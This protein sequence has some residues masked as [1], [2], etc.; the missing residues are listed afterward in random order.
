MNRKKVTTVDD[1]LIHLTDHLSSRMADEQE[2]T[3]STLRESEEFDRGVCYGAINAI[4]DIRQY[5][6]N[7]EKH[8][9]D[10]LLVDDWIKPESLPTCDEDKHDWEFVDHGSAGYYKCLKCQ[11][12]YNEQT[13]KS[14]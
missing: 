9:Y 7:I 2:Y 1:M 4:D 8:G 12:S 11:R 10:H 5:L 13:R 6:R 14:E 3:I